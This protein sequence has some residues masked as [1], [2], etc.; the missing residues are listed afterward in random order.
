MYL[1]NLKNGKMININEYLINRQT[2]EKTNIYSK[3]NPVGNKRFKLYKNYGDFHNN[4]WKVWQDI[5][6][7]YDSEVYDN[8]NKYKGIKLCVCLSE[9]DP[10]LMK[11]P[12]I[13]LFINNSKNNFGREGDFFVSYREK[14]IEVDT[15]GDGNYV[16]YKGIPDKYIDH[17][18]GKKTYFP[19]SDDTMLLLYNI[20][21]HNTDEGNK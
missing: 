15:D 19:I 16:I 17:I 2:K 12:M 4:H 5:L 6:N 7:I 3:Y 18:E 10:D 20:L 21:K 13:Y 14:E 1:V 8:N 9:P 11:Y